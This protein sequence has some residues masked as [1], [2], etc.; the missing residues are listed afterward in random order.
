M[1]VSMYT[2][3]MLRIVMK[4]HCTR[5]V[6]RCL[7]MAKTEEIY[8]NPCHNSS[9]YFF[10]FSAFHFPTVGFKSQSGLTSKCMYCNPCS[11]LLHLQ[12]FQQTKWDI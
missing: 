1:L 7:F 2:M 3:P 8:M 11:T 12:F 5:M 6:I 10:K 4:P 9:K